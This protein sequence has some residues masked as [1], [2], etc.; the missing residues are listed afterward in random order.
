MELT[1]QRNQQAS[2]EGA[3]NNVCEIFCSLVSKNIDVFSPS[4]HFLAKL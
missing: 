4:P 1:T 2:P 3:A